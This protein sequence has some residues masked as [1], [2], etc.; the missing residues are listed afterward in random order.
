MPNLSKR[1]F[2]VPCNSFVNL[3]HPFPFKNATSKWNKACIIVFEFY[4]A[5]KAREIGY[6][7]L[8]VLQPST[9]KFPN[10]NE[11]AVTVS[12]DVGYDWEKGEEQVNSYHFAL[13]M[14]ILTPEIISP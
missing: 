1:S 5:Q 4:N 7:V 12:G 2:Q 8:V 11:Y 6:V 9:N 13:W 3:Q 14:T 10:Q